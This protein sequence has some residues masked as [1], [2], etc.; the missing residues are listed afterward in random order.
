MTPHLLMVL[1]LLSQLSL[2]N[3]QTNHA[4]DNS[5]SSCLICILTPNQINDNTISL[6]LETISE[7]FVFNVE[8]EDVVNL[9]PFIHYFGRAPPIS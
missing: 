2:L 1:F 4:K 9:Q 5:Q 7:S 3:H 8:F 6:T